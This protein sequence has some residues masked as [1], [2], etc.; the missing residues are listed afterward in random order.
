M[1]RLDGVLVQGVDSASLVMAPVCVCGADPSGSSRLAQ[2]SCA[3]C[4]GRLPQAPEA[5]RPDA[6]ERRRLQD[7]LN[8]FV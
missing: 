1:V 4:G 8:A 3:V 7:F 5:A 2:S 6:K